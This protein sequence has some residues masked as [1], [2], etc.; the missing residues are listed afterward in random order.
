MMRCGDVIDDGKC[1]PIAQAGCESLDRAGPGPH[2]GVRTLSF[3]DFSFVPHMEAL[4]P[5]RLLGISELE[6]VSGFLPS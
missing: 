6:A 5:R 2:Q 1:L 3:P 4:C